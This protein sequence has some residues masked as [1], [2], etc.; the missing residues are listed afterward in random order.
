[1]RRSSRRRR[2]RRRRSSSRRRRR[3]R[4]SPTCCVGEE[5]QEAEEV[6]G[7]SRIVCN[8]TDWLH[9]ASRLANI[10]S[11]MCLHNFILFY[12]FLSYL[13]NQTL[14]DRSLGIYLKFYFSKQLKQ[15]YEIF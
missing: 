2:R 7:Y 6:H 12:I 13:T 8:L 9:Y 4:R 11:V 15:Y 14:I 1:V 5:K 10:M 3:R